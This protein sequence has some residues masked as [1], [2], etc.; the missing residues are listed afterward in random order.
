MKT[1]QYL[2]NNWTYSCPQIQ[3]HHVIVKFCE[4]PDHI[5]CFYS[6]FAEGQVYI[7]SQ[8]NPSTRKLIGALFILHLP[9]CDFFNCLNALYCRQQ[10]FELQDHQMIDSTSKF[11]H[12]TVI[13]RQAV[14]Y[15]KLLYILQSY[16]FGHIVGKML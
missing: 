7:T 10:S 8:F 15:N 12:L 1:W 9:S 6:Y 13:D 2:M 16:I 4:K 3:T 14:V 11:K 5:G